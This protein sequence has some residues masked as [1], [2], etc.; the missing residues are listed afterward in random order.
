MASLV[1]CG[2]AIAVVFVCSFV[3]VLLYLRET[4]STLVLEPR[5]RHAPIQ[6]LSADTVCAIGD[7]HGDLEQGRTALRLAGLINVQG[8]WSG[9]KAT[10]VQ[11]G[12][13]LDRGP[14]SLDLVELFE[15]LK[16]KLVLI[17]V[18]SIA[19]V[20]LRSD[21]NFP[22]LLQ[23]EA[24]KAG[25]KV[26]TLL[27]NHEAMNLLGDYRYVSPTELQTLDYVQEP[28]PLTLKAASEAGLAA[29][30]R[31]MR[32]VLTVL[33]FPKFLYISMFANPLFSTS[34]LDIMRGL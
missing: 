12:D 29:W 27:G 15:R 2:K 11:T 17:I 16:V 20:S 3:V 31:R 33:R 23:G 25:G 18:L 26:Y 9:G 32:K 13:L 1:C 28:R 19:Q 34:L 4:Q 24:A 6:V 5:I 10:L 14:N 7:L 21:A 30:R 8:A 22:A